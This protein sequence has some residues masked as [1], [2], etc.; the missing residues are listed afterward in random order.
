MRTLVDASVA[1]RVVEIDRGAECL[2]EMNP[3]TQA[4]KLLIPNAVDPANVR[5]QS[6][7]VIEE[8]SFTSIMRTRKTS[9][10][11]LERNF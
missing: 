6:R 10:T 2:V 5:S 7:K 11:S 3:H 9:I 4:T 8:K 1:D